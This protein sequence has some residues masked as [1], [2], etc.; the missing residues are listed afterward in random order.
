MKTI[1]SQTAK[2]IRK[3]LKKNFPETKFSVRS[4]TFAGGDSVNV[5]WTDGVTEDQVNE[6]IKKYQEG[7]FDGM[8]DLYEYSNDRKDIPQVR[9]VFAE[10]NLSEDFKNAIANAFEIQRNKTWYENGT[11]FDTEQE[12]RSF[13][14]K[15]DRTT[16]QEKRE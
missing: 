15:I 14:S 1:A 6:I 10:R 12:I 4:K 8:R 9:F 5:D 13:A 2:E 16:K 3:E 7:H 11:M